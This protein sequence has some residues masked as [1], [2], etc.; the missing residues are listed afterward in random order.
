MLFLQQ[1]LTSS[2]FLSHL[3]LDFTRQEKATHNDGTK[4]EVGL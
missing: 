1:S 2:F 4:G 3:K